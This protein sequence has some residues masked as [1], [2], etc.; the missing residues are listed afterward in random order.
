LSCK[1]YLVKQ[2]DAT[3]CAAYVHPLAAVAIG[4]AVVAAVYSAGHWGLGIW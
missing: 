4:T 1:K 2:H 3:D